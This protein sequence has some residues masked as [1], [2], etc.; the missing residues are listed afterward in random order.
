MTK[1][2]LIRH[3]TLYLFSFVILL[4]FVNHINKSYYSTI[5]RV[6]DYEI[7]EI[8]SLLRCIL[9]TNSSQNISCINQA[10]DDI[11]FL[12]IDIYQNDQMISSKKIKNGEADQT[13]K[14]TFTMDTYTVNFY[15]RKFPSAINDYLFYLKSWLYILKGQ[16]PFLHTL[17]NTILLYHIIVV[18]LL[19]LTL[20]IVSAKYRIR[21][22]TKR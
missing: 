5:S 19:E 18:L 16:N 11:K 1:R 8:A 20:T 2:N 10:F 22:I 7:I 13:T 14:Q 12:A 9:N 6:N 4:A 3:L 21:Q 15:K 17:F